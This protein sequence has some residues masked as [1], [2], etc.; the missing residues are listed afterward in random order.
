MNYSKEIFV[1]DYFDIHNFY[2]KIY[3]KK[4]II[5]MQVGSFH[6]CYGTDSHGL[7]KEQIRL[8]DRFDIMNVASGGTGHQ[9]MTSG[10]KVRASGTFSFISGI[11]FY[12]CFF[13]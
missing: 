1:K 10:D 3:G 2:E 4:T 13:I 11:V 7:G 9:M 12:Y 5:L 6:E 8:A